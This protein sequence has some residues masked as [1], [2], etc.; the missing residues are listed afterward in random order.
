MWCPIDFIQLIQFWK[1]LKNL[2]P[3]SVF[4]ISRKEIPKEEFIFSERKEN[5]IV[6]VHLRFITLSLTFN[7]VLDLLKCLFL[8]GFPTQILWLFPNSPV[9]FS[10]PIHPTPFQFKSQHHY[11]PSTNH[12]PTDCSVLFNCLKI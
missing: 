3:R 4:S 9:N 2:Y 8:S 5:R 10:F 1:S 6:I 11:I 7:L 12:A